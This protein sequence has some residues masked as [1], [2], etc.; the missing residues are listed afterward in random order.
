MA[1]AKFAQIARQ[2][3]ETLVLIQLGF[4]AVLTGCFQT[5]SVCGFPTLLFAAV[6]VVTVPIFAY[7][8]TDS[9]H[10][11]DT[12]AAAIVVLASLTVSLKDQRA[13]FI[14]A[15][16]AVAMLAASLSLGTGLI[17]PR[18]E[19]RHCTLDQTLA[20][21]HDR[22][23]PILAENPLVPITAGQRPI[24]PRFFVHVP[25]PARLQPLI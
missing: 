3:P 16:L 25:Y 15:T 21:I 11:V 13:D 24:P 5:R 22:Q 10:L 1:P 9:N 6:L 4:A 14:V 19:Q 7:A 23:R 20:L 18:A 12:N 2:V 8:G 17:N